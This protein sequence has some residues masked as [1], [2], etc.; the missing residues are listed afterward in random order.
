MR[1]WSILFSARLW[2]DNSKAVG[3]TAS[4]DDFFSHCRL[5]L[6]RLVDNKTRC[7]GLSGST[8]Q[9][10]R[11]WPISGS[12]RSRNA[13]VFSVQWLTHVTMDNIYDGAGPELCLDSPRTAL[14]H[15]CVT[16]TTPFVTTSS[17]SSSDTVQGSVLL[18]HYRTREVRPGRIS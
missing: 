16:L 18:P 5:L 10:P 4:L 6:I 11:C 7:H 12:H 8:L 14:Q 17:S 1:Y 15:Y 9:L 2:L 13:H 3:S